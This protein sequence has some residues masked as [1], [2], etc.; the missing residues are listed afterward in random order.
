MSKDVH[1]FEIEWGGRPL[2][3]EIGK[4]ANQAD[5]SC[6]VT[7]GETTVL[8]TVVLGA[9]RDIDFFPLTV[10]FEERLYAAG[11]IKGSRFIKREGKATD[12]AVL[13]ARVVDR[14]LRPLFN[15]KMRN[16]VQVVCTV[17]SMDGENDPDILAIIGASLALSISNIPWDGPIGGVRVGQ[18]DGELILN[19]SY[20][21]Q[22]KSALDVTISGTPDKILMLEAGAKEVDEKTINDAIL[23]GQKNLKPLMK[24][25]DEIV[26]KV[27]KEK[28]SID[29]LLEEDAETLVEKQE[30]IKKAK[31]FLADHL[32]EY[33]FG[34][35]P[36]G[37]KS[38]R[39]QAKEDLKDRLVE[40]LKSEQIG[41]DK[42]K[43]ALGVFDDIVEARVLEAILKEGKRVD[44][45]AITEIR[46]LFA[47]VGYLPRVHGSG[48]FAR[49][50]TQVLSII[51]LGSPGDEQIMDTMEE[52]DTKKRFMHHYNFP[53]FSVGDT[54]PMRGPSRR[55]IG[56]GALAEKA[57]LPVIPSKE[58]FP[59]TIRVVSEVMG[60][61]GSSSMGSTCGSTLALMDAGVPIKK[62]VAGIAMGLASDED[63]KNFIVITDLQDMEDSK[64][65]MDFKIAGTRDGIT[66][67]Q[68]D[69]KTA[70]ITKEVVEKT[71]FQAKDARIE[72]LDVMAKTIPEPRGDLSQYAPRIETIHI[73]PDK[74]R[75]VIGPGGKIINGIIDKTGVQIDIEQDGSV[76][77]T[78]TSAEGMEKAKEMINAIIEEP[79]VG[80]IYRGKVVRIMNFGAFVEILPGKDGMVHVSE[81]APFRVENVEDVVKIG[82]EIPVI[83]TEIDDQGRVNLSLKKAREKLGEAQAEQKP[84]SGNGGGFGGDRDSRPPRR[85]DRR[86]GGRPQ[87]GGR[88]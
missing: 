38:S 3:V 76:F 53:P 26:T 54:K 2:K 11:K 35:L 17:L 6:V 69:T 56:H 83:V 23:F 12:E 52:A 84:G 68:M 87:R 78:S 37:S 65:G 70:G 14:G 16:D 30:I 19:P 43:W 60:S 36:K 22:E 5:G 79:E 66:A 45:R 61:N 59:Y 41:K 55:D 49:G 57:L 58:E 72:I 8:S 15:K 46:P 13:S 21:E 29:G 1:N 39:K 10:E 77:I 44:G 63:M 81:L 67:I 74:I 47:D 62:P 32:D 50:E 33:L 88:R 4:I 80:K 75:E 82:D 51:T 42:R 20:A 48:L 73:L 24:L 64:G 86:S 27:G 25:I 18:I 85:D 34:K 40:Y 9:P 7:Y 28:L 31:V 71:L